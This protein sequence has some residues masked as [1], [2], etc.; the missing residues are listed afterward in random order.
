MSYRM[1]LVSK[2]RQEDIYN[3]VLTTINT[4]VCLLTIFIPILYMVLDAT[5]YKK[6][7]KALTIVGFLLLVDSVVA[8]VW[9]IYRIVS[10]FNNVS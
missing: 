2:G 4:I 10:L 3:R 9:A 7:A 1:E 8:L 5:G 6:A